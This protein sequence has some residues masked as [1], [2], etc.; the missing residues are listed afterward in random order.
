MATIRQA[1]HH[2]RCTSRGGKDFPENILWIP[3]NFHDAWHFI[4]N[5]LNK[6]EIHLFIDVLYN[7]KQANWFE[8]SRMREQIKIHRTPY[9]DTIWV[10]GL[11]VSLGQDCVNFAMHK[12]D[13]KVTHYYIMQSSDEQIMQSIKNIITKFLN[14]VQEKAMIYIT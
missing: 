14:Q 12:Q 1:K 7:L 2:K 3:E 4:F 6:D 5:N 13:G 11:S 8:I 10:D 9:K